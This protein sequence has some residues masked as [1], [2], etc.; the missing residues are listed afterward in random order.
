MCTF[1]PVCSGLYWIPIYSGYTISGHVTWGASDSMNWYTGGQVFE[2]DCRVQIE[3]TDDIITV[4]NNTDY[5]MVDG[6]KMDIR[7]TILRGV[8]ELNRI[9]LDLIERKK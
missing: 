4:I 3:Y 7:K 2:G 1:C 6:K 9:L 5:V 8:K